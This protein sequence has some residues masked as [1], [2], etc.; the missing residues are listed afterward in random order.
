MKPFK[1]FIGV[2]EANPISA[3]LNKKILTT[4]DTLNSYALSGKHI[5]N[6]IVY[7]R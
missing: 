4:T 2:H 5:I 7:M 3:I 1:F 6:K